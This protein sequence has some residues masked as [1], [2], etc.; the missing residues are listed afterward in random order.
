MSD[1]ITCTLE[2]ICLKEKG[3]IISGPFGSNISSKYFVSSGIPVIRGN[4]L[5]TDHIKFIDDGFVYVTEEKANELHCDAYADDLIFTAAGTIGQV[6]IIPKN[7][8]YNRYVISN[9][10]IRVRL[11][12]ELVDL[13]YAYCWFVSPWIQTALKNNNKG[14]TVP[15]LTLAEVRS[16]PITYPK[17]KGEQKA[18][19]KVFN[20]L[21]AKI[22]NNVAICSDLEAIAKLLYNYWFVQFDFPDENGKP[23]KSS[24]GKMVWNEELK[25]EIPDGWEVKPLSKVLCLLKDGTHNPPKRMDSGIP[26]LTGTMFGD[27]FLDYSQ[28]TYI[29]EDNYSTIHKQY[30]PEAGDIVITKIGT[31]GNVNYLRDKDIPIAIHCNSALLRFPDDYCGMFA[32]QYCKSKEFF[33]RLKA[34][35]GQSVQEFCSLD[36]I[37]SILMLVPNHNLTARYND[38]MKSVL[39]QMINTQSENQELASLR[40][41]L[42]P[43]LMNGQVKV[44]KEDDNE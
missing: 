14:S 22:D 44:K 30:K 36:S 8:K 31:L 16:L 41:F 2:D 7:T 27:Y 18:I 33:A 38:N 23:Y 35:K 32:F 24:G 5:T 4:N 3:S 43:M 1:L 29:T 26:L 42:L 25:R 12:T 6:G 40:D 11:D 39:N 21:D 19:A 9:K 15:L 17:D 37:G 34:A 28:A 13:D 20:D 10:Q